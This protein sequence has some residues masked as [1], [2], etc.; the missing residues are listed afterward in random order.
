MRVNRISPLLAFSIVILSAAFLATATQRTSVTGSHG[1][2]LPSKHSTP[3]VEQRLEGGYWRSD[4]T[5]RPML[6]VTNILE[7][8]E[9]PVTPSLY[10]ADGTEYQLPPVTLGPAGVSF[11]DIIAALSAAPDE[12]K[13]HFSEHGSASVKYVWHSPGAVSAMVQNRDAKRSLNFNFDLRTPM[14]MKHSHRRP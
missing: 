4:H 2:N 14:V 10:A 13:N 3:L 9:L 1:S 8:A 6:I 5:F 11:I 12:I 7:N